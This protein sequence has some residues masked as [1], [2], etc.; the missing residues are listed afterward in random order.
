M[1]DI[2]FRAWNNI[3]NKMVFSPF[4][5]PK[6]EG[7]CYAVS[8]YGHRYELMQYTGIKDREG[9][10]I[11]EGDVLINQKGSVRWNQEYC[12]FEINNFEHQLS[13]D[14][15]QT[16]GLKVVGNIYENPELL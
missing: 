2:K 7:G 9:T 3:E 15:I 1:R 16:L 13:K 4:L 14:V 12:Y 11:Y 10:E 8:G 6:R 5:I